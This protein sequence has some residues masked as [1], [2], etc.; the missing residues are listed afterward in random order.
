[1]LVYAGFGGY[2]RLGHTVQQDEH[3]PKQIAVFDRQP[4]DK[5]SIVGFASTLL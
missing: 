3:K 5:N 1:M 4:V 2:G